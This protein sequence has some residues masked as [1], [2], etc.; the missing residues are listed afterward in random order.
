MGDTDAPPILREQAQHAFD[1]AAHD[2][3]AD[4]DVVPVR[5]RD[6]HSTVMNAVDVYDDGQARPYA[7]QREQLD[8][9]SDGDEHGAL[10]QHAQLIVREAGRRAHDEDGREVRHEHREDVLMP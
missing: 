1:D 6:A 8:E 2:D 7:P 3:G 5:G 10:H 4:G 9:R